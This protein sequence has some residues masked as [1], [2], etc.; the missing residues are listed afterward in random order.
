MRRRPAG[1]HVGGAAG[2]VDGRIALAWRQLAWMVNQVDGAGLA[3]DRPDVGGLADG[4]EAD[5]G[6]NSKRVG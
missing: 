6:I 3:G 4:V 5:Q 1:A 2:V